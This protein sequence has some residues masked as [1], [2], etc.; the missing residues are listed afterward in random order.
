M[1]KDAEVEIT[2][3][4]PWSQ[5]LM[6][7]EAKLGIGNAVMDKPIVNRVAKSNLITFDLEV[8][9]QRRTEGSRYFSMALGRYGPE[10][11]G[12]PQCC[13][14][15]GY[16][17]LSNTFVALAVQCRCYCPCLGFHVGYHKAIRNRNQSGCWNT[18]ESWKR[19]LYTE[20]I[21]SMD[22]TLSG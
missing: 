2:F 4:P 9:S 1:V 11:K 17:A 14:A 21:H 8:L 3:D 12:I 15:V 7:E 5:D 18:W 20:L 13:C 22:F 16:H 19:T 10:G 6:S